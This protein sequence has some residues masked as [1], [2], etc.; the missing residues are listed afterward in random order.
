MAIQMLVEN[1]IK[2]GISRLP[3]G[4]EVNIK[5]E[6]VGDQLMVEVVNTGQLSEPDPKSSGIGLQN[7]TDRLKL[8]FG[9]TAELSLEN[10][11]E[12]MV[13]ASFTVPLTNQ[14]N[15]STSRRRF[16]VGS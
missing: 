4:G 5:C 6:A 13:K 3:R 10:L 14:S 9:K 11:N 1:A 7:A 15:E 8:L 2:H 16:K 12:N